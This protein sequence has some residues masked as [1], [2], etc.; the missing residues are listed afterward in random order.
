LPF[1][2]TVSEKRLDFSCMFTHGGRPSMGPAFLAG[3]GDPGLHALAYA[4]GGKL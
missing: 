3:L 2:H 1:A 4:N